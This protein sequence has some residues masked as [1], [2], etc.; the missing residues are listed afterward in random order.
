MKKNRL[1]EGLITADAVPAM[2]WASDPHGLRTYFNRA[3]LKFTGRMLQQEIGNG[4][5]DGVK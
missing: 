3:W 1:P 4:W 2:V 5:T